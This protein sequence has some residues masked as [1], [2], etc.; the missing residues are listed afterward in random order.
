ME[1][2]CCRL[3]IHIY[4]DSDLAFLVFDA[5]RIHARGQFKTLFPMSYATPSW[6]GRHKE[7]KHDHLQ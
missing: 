5:L 7:E 6:R 3:T 4:Y 2:F 1:A